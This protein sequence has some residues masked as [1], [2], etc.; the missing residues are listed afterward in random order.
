MHRRIRTDICVAGG[1]SGGFGAAL[2]AS[3]MGGKVLLF[4]SEDLLGGTS[5]VS[6]VN[7]WEPVA[8]AAYGAPRELYER[9]K[10]I[11]GGCGI[12][13]PRLHRSLG[14]E[15]CRDFP[16]GLSC[17]DPALTYE[18]TLKKGFDYRRISDLS[19]WN[20]IIFEPRI[21]DKCAREMLEENHVAVLTGRR[22]VEVGFTDEHIRSVTLDDG[23][24][25]EAKIWIDNSSF[26]AASS[27]CRLLYGSEPFSL[28]REPDAPETPEAGSLN[29][30]TLLF[31]ATPKVSPGVDALPEALEDREKRQD[32]V[33]VQY[34]CG[35]L[36]CNMLPTLRGE[37]YLSLGENAARK[38][39]EERVLVFWHT[40][41]KEY[42]FLRHYALKSFAPKLG[43]RES[44]RTV[45]R[46]MLTEN[47]VLG[48]LEEQEQGDCVAISDHQ[49]DRHGAKGPGRPV[50]PYGIP[51]GA[52]LPEGKDNLLVAGRIGGFSSLAS[53]SCRL[54][55]TMIR[56][57]E[58]AGFAAFLALRDHCPLEK[59]DMRKLQALMKFE[60]EKASIRQK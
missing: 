47:E 3:R 32:M 38:V 36:Y 40:V 27:R 41:Q 1:G 16:G 35:D 7:C 20:G 37:E 48:G 22:A 46:K 14:E 49:L 11:P 2:A 31:R 34:P 15:G 5:T 21:W 26:L 18:D 23:T 28:F 42:E 25:I 6:G 57:G 19:K 44:F 50:R 56:L 55:R 24:Q 30:V 39:C 58:A 45:C 54:S 59:V 33:A 17:I 4:E 13:T 29:G 52:L 43:I 8:G 53:S 10:K 12:Y 60:E 9:M 51:C